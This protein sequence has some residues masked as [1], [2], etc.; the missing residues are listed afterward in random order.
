[1]KI[2]TCFI[3]FLGFLNLYAQDPV[4]IWTKILGGSDADYARSIHQTTDG[5]YIVAG[6]T[7]SNDGDIHG[8]HGNNDYW[9]VKLT[10]TGDTSWT[11]T[12]GGSNYDYARLIQ[13]TTDGGYIVVGRST[14]TDGDV[15]GNH[16][17]TDYWIVKLTATGD[18][19]WTKALGGTSNDMAQSIQQ[20]TDGGYIVAG[21]SYSSDGDVYENH[22]WADYWI[23]KLTA[24]GDTSWTKVLGGSNRDYVHSIQ[25]TTDGGYIIAGEVL[26]NDG[27]IHGNHGSYDYW[28]VK[29]TAAGDTSWTKTLG[30]SDADYAQSIQ[31]ATDGG[32]IVAGYTYSNDG[33]VHG[34]HGNNDYWIVKLTA[35]GDTSWT[36]TLGGSSNDMATSVQQTTDNGYIV[37]G[38]AASSDG[39]VHENN[40]NRDYWIIK[41][42][43]TGDTSWTKTLGG[44]GSDWTK[45]DIIQQTTDGEYIVT[46]NTLSNDGD[47]QGNH[48]DYDYW[49]VKF[50]PL[51]KI[52]TDIND[53][54]WCI[55]ENACLK[56]DATGLNPLYQWQKNGADMLERTYD[57]LLF[58]NFNYSD[59]G[60]Y[61]CIVTNIVGKDTS[62]P[63]K[64]KV[65]NLTVTG[66]EKQVCYDSAITL[67]AILNSNHPAESG[68]I[69]YTWSPS[70]GIDDTEIANPTAMPNSSSTY[71]VTVEDE[72]GCKAT[73]SMHVFVQNVYQDEQ[74][75]L[76]TSDPQTGHN[77]VVWEK[78]P[79]KGTHHF[80]IYR[81]RSGTF[82]KI[83]ERP[84]DSVS[85]FVD[86]TSLFENQAEIYKITTTDTCGNESSLDSAD[87]HT[88]IFLQWNNNTGGVNLGWS[89][90]KVNN[91]EYDFDY[92]ILYRGSD[93]TAL[94]SITTVD[95]T[96]D[97]YTDNSPEALTGKYYYRIAGVKTPYCYANSKLKTSAGP[98]SQSISNLE[99]NRLKGDAIDDNL[100]SRINL[101]IYPN[102]F[103]KLTTIAYTLQNAANISIEV[104]NV[105]NEKVG[106]I[107]NQS[108]EPGDYRYQYNPGKPGVY[109]LQF[110]MDGNMVTKKI[111]GL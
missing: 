7:Y 4:I 24:T 15:H 93:S 1:M 28:I 35:T 72:V 99:D 26:S 23:V 8:N 70:T 98:F 63:A 77:M 88:T 33:D 65:I 58:Q 40:G 51:P 74:I 6:H 5:G 16:G 11:K 30:G 111:I 89:K 96:A 101:Q 78:T 20:T 48:G 94:D 71:Y 61:R 9:I 13:Q 21:E 95:Y 60:R 79:N 34:N 39:D 97:R 54:V 27:D 50:D 42:T 103:K 57:T 84:F 102:P 92:Y 104:Y 31:Q 81:K 25:Q 69:N 83:G 68:V 52:K 17:E 3:L 73:D 82:Q 2:I 38:D 37:A 49:I 75:C 100:A 46:G 59:T 32:Y 12:L 109:Y 19:S 80:N 105:I 22:G 44:T 29:L 10:A 110:R 18:T 45:G 36:K 86:A 53:T 14:S 106:I 85:V 107:V 87:S 108:Q 66:I 56:I 47:V 67:Q 64:L 43:A 41:L 90:Y 91:V 62:N 76:L 55:G